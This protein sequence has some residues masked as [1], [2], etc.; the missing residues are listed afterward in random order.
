M[1]TEAPKLAVHT[2]ATYRI[3]VQGYL[4]KKWSDFLEG[5]TIVIEQ[6]ERQHPVTTLTGQVMDQAALFG[7]LIAL[8]DYHMPLLSV[9]CLSRGSISQ[10]G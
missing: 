1:E 7:V 3:S 10:E 2:P 6:N 9:E 8:Y 4:D 5:M